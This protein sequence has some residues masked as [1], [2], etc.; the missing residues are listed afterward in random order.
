MID[1]SSGSDK[2][3]EIVPAG[4]H[5]AILYSI[6]ELGTMD[7]EYMGTPKTSRKVRLTWELPEEKR[8]FDG[9]EKPMVVGKTYTISLYEGSRLR[10]IVV[11]MLGGLTEEQ[12]ETFDIKSLLGKACM[13]QVAPEDWDGKKF[14][15][16]ISA[17][18]LPD[19][20]PNL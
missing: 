16:V 13:L 2:E 3:R 20:S 1:F 5:V 10:P 14:A 9:E 7:T 19:D 4:N 17:A 12:E 11:G 18:Q 6:I 8:E 15:S